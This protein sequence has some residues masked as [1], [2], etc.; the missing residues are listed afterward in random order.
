MGGKDTE[1]DVRSMTFTYANKCYALHGLEGLSVP[2]SA[3]RRSPK[4][5]GGGV[6][7]RSRSVSPLPMGE[8]DFLNHV[9]MTT[10]TRTPQCCAACCLIVIVDELQAIYVCLTLGRN[11]AHAR[12]TPLLHHAMQPRNPK[13]TCA[14]C[15]TPAHPQKTVSHNCSYLF[16]IPPST[17]LRKFRLPHLLPPQHHIQHPLHRTQHLLIR[18]RRPLLKL[19][20]HRWRRIALC[21]QVLLR[22]RLALFILAVRP[23]RLDGVADARADGLGLDDVVGP[24]DF[25]EVLAFESGFGGLN[26]SGRLVS[27]IH[28]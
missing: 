13:F 15:S 20:H 17:L 9:T 19:R 4:L 2:M 22:H 18:R 14:T 23:R 7:C 3:A 25:G 27:G 16:P 21:R 28:R 26:V 24:V 1:N 12:A 11:D 5:K 6:W 8:Q 10:W